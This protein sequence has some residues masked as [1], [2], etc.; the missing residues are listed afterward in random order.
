MRRMTPTTERCTIRVQ[1]RL[2]A[3]GLSS[4]RRL[5]WARSRSSVAP[6]AG[7]LLVQ[8]R[9]AQMVHIGAEHRTSYVQGDRGARRIKSGVG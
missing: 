3:G 5:R 2:H 8:A 1:H 4:D 7:W 6:T 9:R